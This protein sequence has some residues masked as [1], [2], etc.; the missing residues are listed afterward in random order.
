MTAS[1]DISVDY[2]GGCPGRRRPEPAHVT[3]FSDHFVLQ[4][5]GWGWRIGFTSVV[6]VGDPRP[7]PS[8]NRL[9]L[10]VIWRPPGGE[11]TLLLAGA[12]VRR[13]RFLLA[14]AVAVEQARHE[15]AMPVPA[16]PPA[17]PRVESRWRR[18]LRHMRAVTAAA[19]TAALV[20][21]AVVLGI[22]LTVIGR[23]ATGGHWARERAQLGERSADVRIAQDRNDPGAISLALQ[24][25]VD[26]CHRLEAYDGDSHN[27]GADFAS[28]QQTCASVGVALF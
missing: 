12:D 7:E 21:L 14:Q 26:E 18:E 15:R 27:S 10:P 20:A 8:G 17:L 13:L 2:L 19:M 24:A 5:R 28:V 22:T 25:L 3:V 16:P 23:G 6:R 1:P 4:A 11:Q 9:V